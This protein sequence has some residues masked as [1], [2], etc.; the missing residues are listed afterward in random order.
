MCPSWGVGVTDQMKD[1]KSKIE[2]C[3]ES[4]E[5]GKEVEALKKK[6]DNLEKTVK[7]IL[8]AL[9]KNNIQIEL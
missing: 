1:L 6:Y 5:Y 2:L 9:E 3:D 7:A 4:E 8:K